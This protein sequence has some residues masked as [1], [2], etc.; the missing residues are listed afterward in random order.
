[1][2]GKNWLNL[3]PIQTTVISYGTRAFGIQLS[4]LVLIKIGSQDVTDITGDSI[5]MFAKDGKVGTKGVMSCQVAG[6]DPY[7]DS[8]AFEWGLYHTK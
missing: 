6:D 8:I 2:G 5:R 3:G 7:G 1:M 4:E